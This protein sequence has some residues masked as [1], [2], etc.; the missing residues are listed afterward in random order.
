MLTFVRKKDSDPRMDERQNDPVV[1]SDLNTDDANDKSP[2]MYKPLISVTCLGH[3]D[4]AISYFKSIYR[5][6]RAPVIKCIHYMVCI[7]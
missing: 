5:A 6:F 2:V 3:G 1:L 4:Q 7:L